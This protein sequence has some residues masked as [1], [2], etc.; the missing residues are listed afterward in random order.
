MSLPKI[1]LQFMARPLP[2]LSL[3]HDELQLLKENEPEQETYSHYAIANPYPTSMC[4]NGPLIL[5]EDDGDDQEFLI[6]AIQS[7]GVKNEIKVFN[8]GD[9]ALS[10]L[11]DTTDQPLLILSDVNMPKTN[12]IVLKKTIDACETLKSKCI[13]FF[14]MSTSSNESLRQKTCELAIQGFFQK[15]NSFQELKAALRNIL[16]PWS[17]ALQIN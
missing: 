1:N 12:G 14:F 9:E 16:A 4:K 3:K 15:G 10:Y 11:Y 7:L 2:I 6:S 5:V 8:N 17:R 13:P